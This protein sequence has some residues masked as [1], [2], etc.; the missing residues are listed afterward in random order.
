MKKEDVE[1]L[2]RLRLIVGYLSEA[3]QY[4]WIQSSFL[5]ESSEAF[6]KPIFP[7]TQLLA[8]YRGV[9]AAS[10]HLYDQL[11]GK[12]SYHLYRLPDVWE[13]SLG[14]A[15][16]SMDEFL[17]ESTDAA[18]DELSALSNSEEQSEGPVS[19]GEYE[20]DNLNEFIG[21]AA[22]LYL[23]AFKNG[24]QVFPYLRY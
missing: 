20:E 4:G 23:N 3:S 19:L 1:A 8:Q 22:G 12:G 13:R 10:Q 9:C 21:N 6:L 16:K 5:K 18:L 14:E 24:R 17:F 7:R 15:V 2:S 11:V